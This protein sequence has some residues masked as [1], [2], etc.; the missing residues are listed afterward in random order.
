MVEYLRV[1]PHE[2][3]HDYD[4]VT[5]SESIAE[6]ESKRCSLESVLLFPSF[7]AKTDYAL[8]RESNRF[9]AFWG[10]GGVSNKYSVA[11]N[12]CLLSLIF[13]RGDT[14]LAQSFVNSST[15]NAGHVEQIFKDNDVG[16]SSMPVRYFIEELKDI[17]MAWWFERNG[18]L[19]DLNDR[20]KL[21]GA[22]GERVTAHS[23]DIAL[24]SEFFIPAKYSDYL[25]QAVANRAD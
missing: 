16:R 18:G 19:V 22:L 23:K 14:A 21:V 20:P 12:V 10:G 6:A 9:A 13:S 15:V 3:G 5:W 7:S 4:W 8:V 2:I 17:A 25:S 1:L 24:P 11:V